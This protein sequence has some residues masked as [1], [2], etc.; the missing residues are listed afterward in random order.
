MCEQAPISCPVIREREF[1][2]GAA[3]LVAA[4]RLIV[5]DQQRVA[6][7][8]ERPVSGDPVVQQLLELRMQ[9]DV[10]VVV[11]LADRDA[12]PVSRADLHD[13]VDSQAEQFAAADGGA[14]QQLDDEPG[15]RVGIG[16]RSSRAA[17]ASS[18]NRGSSL[19]TM[20]RSP[21]NTSGRADAS[22]H[23]RARAPAGRAHPAI[24]CGR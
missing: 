24:A 6:A 15:E 3:D 14:G 20:G 8:A 13:G 12:Q 1:A 19:S 9:Q 17:A 2:Q 22:G 4:D 21:V 23:L 11:E 5:L 18:G 10:T 16:A 7:R